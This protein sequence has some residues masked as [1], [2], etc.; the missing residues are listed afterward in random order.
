MV[1]AHHFMLAFYPT[2]YDSNPSRA[3]TSWLE[4]AYYKYPLNVLTNGNFCVTIFFVLSGYVLS[5][6]YMKE[7]D[8]SVIVSASKRRFFRLFIPVGFVLICSYILLQI[9]AY[10]HIEVSK[11]SMSEWWLGTLWPMDP[12]FGTFLRYFSYLVM[13]QGSADYDTSM[14]TM[15]ME[16]YG[17]FLVFGLLAV[18]HYVRR[19]NIIF[20]ISLA[21]LFAMQKYYYLCF[22]FGIMLNSIDDISF[23]KTGL[24][25]G[26]VLVP[27]LIFGGL[28]LGSFPSYFAPPGFGSG[29]WKFIYDWKNGIAIMSGLTY[30]VLHV[31]GSVMVVAGVVLSPLLQKFLSNRFFVFLGLISFSLYLLHPLVLGAFACP[32]FLKLQGTMSYHTAFLTVFL[33]S[34]VLTV[35]LSWLMAITVDKFSVNFS[36]RIFGNQNLKKVPVKAGARKQGRIK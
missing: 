34:I 20:L 3:H 32:L 26:Y 35:L 13:F 22:V 15:S 1:L 4:F 5:Y 9:S 18:T 8:F 7:N 14:W 11:I 25:I 19:K 30:V 24:W 10:K 29:F 23:T 36:K 21:V 2:A 33:L 28:L 6:K 27:F 31:V 12:S 16:L 17:S